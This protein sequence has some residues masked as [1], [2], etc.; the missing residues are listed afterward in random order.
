LIEVDGDH[1]SILDEAVAE[2]E[3]FFWRSVAP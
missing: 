3:E 1:V 2:V